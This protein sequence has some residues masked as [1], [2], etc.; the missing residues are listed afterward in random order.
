LL[1]D[2]RILMGRGKRALRGLAGRAL[3]HA[4]VNQDRRHGGGAEDEQTDLQIGHP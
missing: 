1:V 3:L 2:Q 4:V